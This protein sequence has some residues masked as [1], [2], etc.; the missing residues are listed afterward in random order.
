MTTPSLTTT[1]ATDAAPSPVRGSLRTTIL[2]L[3]LLPPLLIGGAWLGW[4]VTQQAQRER[5][6]LMQGATQV[7]QGFSD[8]ILDLE[9]TQGRRFIEP[10]L[11]ATVQARAEDLLRSS[12][13]PIT[14]VAV[15]DDTGRIQVA[16]AARYTTGSGG[17]MDNAASVWTADQSSVAQAASALARRAIQTH[18]K[19]GL[20]AQVDTAQGRATLTAVPLTSEAGATVLLLDESRITRSL[21]ASLLTTIA[22]LA[23]LLLTVTLIAA[24]LVNAFLDRVKAFATAADRASQG[25]DVT[26]P[27]T[28]NDE[29]TTLGESL[30]R[31]NTSLQITLA[32]SRRR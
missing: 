30:D 3:V 19:T 22:F 6:L 20:T 29:L 18:A 25:E 13:L 7:A 4:T 17:S 5:A 26:I 11:R 2:P 14:D 23:A 31:L 24:R 27:V 16:Y 32:R 8:R 12:Q 10:E 1:P 28:G 15:T 21:R 9:E